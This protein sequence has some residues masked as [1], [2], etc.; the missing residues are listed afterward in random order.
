MTKSD[1]LL[2]YVNNILKERMEKLKLGD[3]EQMGYKVSVYD[4]F[5]RNF[6]LETIYYELLDYLEENDH[7]RSLIPKV[8]MYY[9]TSL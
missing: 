3:L 1:Q 2:A 7:T 9:Q 8:E 5:E 4:I 6:E